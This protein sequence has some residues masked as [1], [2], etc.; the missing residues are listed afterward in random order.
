MASLRRESE[1]KCIGSSRWTRARNEAELAVTKEPESGPALAVL[2]VIDAELGRKEETC[3]PLRGYKI[4]EHNFQPRL[5]LVTMKTLA[6]SLIAIV[7]VALSSA[8][9]AANLEEGQITGTVVEVYHGASGIVIE[10]ADKK[11]WEMIN[12]SGW[13]NDKLKVGEKVTVHYEIIGRGKCIARKI[14]K[15]GKAEKGSKKN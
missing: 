13:P 3:S 2:G 1:R 5:K 8:V 4:L 6:W 9:F 14:E 7:S 15:A 10:T 11:R 12:D